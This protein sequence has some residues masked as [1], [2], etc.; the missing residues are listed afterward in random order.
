MMYVLGCYADYGKMNT[1]LWI[2]TAISIFTHQSMLLFVPFLLFKPFKQRLTKK[3]LIMLIGFVF[4]FIAIAP[5]IAGKVTNNTNYQES[6]ALTY[7][8]NRLS[9]AKQT[10]GLTMDIV[11]F[12]VVC[13]PMLYI[14]FKN[15]WIERKKISNHVAYM[16]NIALLLIVL[17]IAMQPVPLLQYRYFNTTFSFLPFIYP[18]MFSKIKS[19]DYF[20]K[21]VG[22]SML[23]ILMATIGST[24]RT[25][26][27]LINLICEPPILLIAGFF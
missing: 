12:I 9:N 15:L 17:I 22:F 20:L 13:I 1:K 16:L 10:D 6:S 7:G 27:P 4:V 25:Y 26:A 2:I 8:L 5:N 21:F 3:S 11:Q 23:F 18:F 24:G 14:L 19:R